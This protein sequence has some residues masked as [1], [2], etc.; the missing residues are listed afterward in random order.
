MFSTCNVLVFGP[1]FLV[2]SWAAPGRLRHGWFKAGCIF[3][4]GG[5]GRLRLGRRRWRWN[6]LDGTNFHNKVDTELKGEEG[7]FLAIPYKKEPPGSKTRLIGECLVRMLSVDI[8]RTAC[9]AAWT[10]IQHTSV[11]INLLT[12]GISRSGTS[13]LPQRY[14][15]GT[16]YGTDKLNG[17]RLK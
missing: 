9:E 8:H 1:G 15:Y 16:Q 2:L 14:D 7:N 3:R 10:M 11:T 5:T 12:G 6:Q 4:A 17:S 13:S